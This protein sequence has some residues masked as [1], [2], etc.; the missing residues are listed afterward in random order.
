[1][2]FIRFI[3]FLKKM[4]ALVLHFLDRIFWCSRLGSNQCLYHGVLRAVDADGKKILHDI[5]YQEY[6]DYIEE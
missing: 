2:R 1:M 4:E 3:L 5:D 6:A